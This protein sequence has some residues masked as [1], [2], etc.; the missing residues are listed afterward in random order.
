MVSHIWQQHVVVV[1]WFC[2]SHISTSAGLRPRRFRTR[3]PAGQNVY[4]SSQ[5]P[6]PPIGP[7]QPHA[8]CLSAYVPRVK[9][10]GN[11]VNQ[12]PTTTA[13]VKKSGAPR[14]LPLY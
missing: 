12:S 3:I 11:E 4:L 5:T 6:M 13:E 14:L 10:P 9:R 1:S 8:L 2:E 7:T